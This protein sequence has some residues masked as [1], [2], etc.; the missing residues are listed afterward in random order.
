MKPPADH[1][2]DRRALS[3]GSPPKK[4]IKQEPRSEV[5]ITVIRFRYVPIDVINVI[6]LA[7]TLYCF[8]LFPTRGG[9]LGEQTSNRHRT[10]SDASKK[11]SGARR[12]FITLLV[13]RPTRSEKVV[14]S[15]PPLKDSHT[16]QYS[17]YQY[18][19]TPQADQHGRR[20][21]AVWLQC[22]RVGRWIL[23]GSFRTSP[24]AGLLRYEP[25]IRP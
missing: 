20:S 5:S 3:L 8:T 1:L 24:S 10:P 19:V 21:T 16:N 23:S 9:S 17:R 7:C 25:F 11:A 6:R 22:P 13:R 15:T 12:L 4:E 2:R 18:Y 14:H